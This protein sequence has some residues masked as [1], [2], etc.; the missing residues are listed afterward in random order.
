[1]TNEN[2]GRPG[3]AQ[4]GWR[5]INEGHRPQLD[6]G[7]QPTYSPSNP[8]AGHQPSAPGERPAP[9]TTGSGAIPPAKPSKE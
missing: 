9:P 4:D 8:G 2:K 6:R 1:M 7:H 3:Y 5:P